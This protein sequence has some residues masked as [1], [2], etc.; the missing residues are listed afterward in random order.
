MIKLLILDV[1]GCMSDGKIIYTADGLELKNFN[2]KDGFAIKAWVK[3]GHMAAIITGR[4]SSIVTNRAKEL[5]IA[6]LYQGVKDKRAVAIAMC[7]E[8]GIEPHEVAVIGD[9][10]NDYNLLQWAGQAYTPQDGSDY[11]KTFAHVLERCGGNACVREM[12]E[13]VIRRNGEE[14]KFLALW[15]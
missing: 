9:D 10:L 12:I 14:E 2:V 6:Y 3:M 11:L 4:D 8:L 15:I 7:A 13:K 1:D 5:D